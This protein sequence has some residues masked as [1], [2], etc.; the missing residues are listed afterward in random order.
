MKSLGDFL[1]LLDIVQD[2]CVAKA[3]R[4]QSVAVEKSNQLVIP[5]PC[6]LSTVKFSETAVAK[7]VTFVPVKQKLPQQSVVQL[8]SY[9]TI[10]LRRKQGRWV[11]LKRRD[12]VVVTE[13]SKSSSLQSKYRCSITGKSLTSLSAFQE[14]YPQSTL[15]FVVLLKRFPPPHPIFVRFLQRKMATILFVHL[16]QKNTSCSARDWNS[17]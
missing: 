12:Y 2:T 3:V 4:S 14:Y 16:L 11:V 17:L 15:Q 6:T 7:Q 10:L 9:Q 8:P 1:D 5:P 13:D